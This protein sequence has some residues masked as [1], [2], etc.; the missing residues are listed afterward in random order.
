[1]L[2]YFRRTNPSIPLNVTTKTK[3]SEGREPMISVK[4]SESPICIYSDYGCRDVSCPLNK[5][6]KPKEAFFAFTDIEPPGCIKIMDM[7]FDESINSCVRDWIKA[8]HVKGEAHSVPQEVRDIVECVKPKIFTPLERWMRGENVKVGPGVVIPYDRKQPRI[9]NII[10][11]IRKHGVSFL[12]RIHIF[13]LFHLVYCQWLRFSC[14]LSNLSFNIIFYI[15]SM[16]CDIIWSWKRC[17]NVFLLFQINEK[18]QRFVR[19]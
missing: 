8:T 1:M 4:Y 19:G 14:F 6:H 12:Y 5:L 9:K 11:H 18:D 17:V 3:I 13:R 10:W 2:L 16:I 15:Y 7:L